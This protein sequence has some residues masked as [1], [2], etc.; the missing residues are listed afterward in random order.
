MRCLSRGLSFEYKFQFPRSQVPQRADEKTQEIEVRMQDSHASVRS[1][2]TATPT[3]RSQGALEKS[4]PVVA[5]P[6]ERF[7][8]N[9]R[10][11]L[12]LVSG[13]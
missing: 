9:M 3:Q 7:A 10:I 11:L 8:E 2:L 5:L 6:R 4:G 12:Q 13:K 1:A